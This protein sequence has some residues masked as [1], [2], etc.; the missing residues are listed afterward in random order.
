MRRHK[1]LHRIEQACPRVT[2]QRVA[3]HSIIA[4]CDLHCHS[5]H[6]AVTL[7]RLCLGQAG[8]AVAFFPQAAFFEQ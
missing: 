4:T 2:P 7:L 3:L 8:D 5:G 1:P 6:A